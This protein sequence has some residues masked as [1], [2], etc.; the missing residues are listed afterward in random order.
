MA[1]LHLVHPEIARSSAEMVTALGEQEGSLLLLGG[2]GS[3]V[4][5]TKFPAVA[6]LI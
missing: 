6:M 2:S 3:A 4:V 1:D 5:V